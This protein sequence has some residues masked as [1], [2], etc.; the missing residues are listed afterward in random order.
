MDLW[1]A[2]WAAGVAALRGLP[3]ARMV[4]MAHNVE[5]LIWE[6]YRENEPER[7]RRWYIAAQCRKF[8]RFERRA[9]AEAN[10]VVTVSAR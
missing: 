7:L 8:E 1:Q 10:R 2:E 4:V 6:R 5:T 9:F 3:G